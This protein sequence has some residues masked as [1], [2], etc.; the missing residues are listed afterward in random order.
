VVKRD[1][2]RVTLAA[3]LN[4]KMGYRAGGKIFSKKEAFQQYFMLSQ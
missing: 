4:E 3:F 2:W 1:Q